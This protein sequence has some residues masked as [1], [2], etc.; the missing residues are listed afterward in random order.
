MTSTSTVREPGQQVLGATAQA[1]DLLALQALGKVLGKRKSK[2][3]A[4][5]L[6]VLEFLV[7]QE[8]LKPATHDLDFG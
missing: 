1:Y 4:A 2:V 6:D 5:Q 7:H 3:G 8:G